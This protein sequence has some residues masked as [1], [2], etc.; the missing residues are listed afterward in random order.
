MRI[1]QIVGNT[2]EYEDASEWVAKSFTNEIKAKDYLHFL[3]NKLKDLKG[4]ASWYN[5]YFDK[6]GEI[7]EKM[8][9]FDNNFQL[10]YTG[11]YYSLQ[12]FDVE[13]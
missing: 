13:E 10:D 6:E 7:I 9:P 2:G 12:E 4:E 5:L 11:T 1:Y 3:T 8:K